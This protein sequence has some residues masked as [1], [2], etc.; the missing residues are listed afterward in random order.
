MY[1]I[2]NGLW[3]AKSWTLNWQK[4]PITT[5]KMTSNKIH[6]QNNKQIWNTKHKIINLIIR[7]K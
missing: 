2:I 5:K 1:I 6:E 7:S 3:H 4:K